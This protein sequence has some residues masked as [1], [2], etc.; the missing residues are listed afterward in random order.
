MRTALILAPL[1]ALS[2][3]GCLARAAV[4]VV[5]APVRIAS[6]AVDLATVSQSEADEQRGRE[7]RRREQRLAELENDY[8]ELQD[9]CLD[10]SDRACREAVTLRAE[11]EAL[12]PTIPV[13]PE[14]D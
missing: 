10:G 3:E 13:E 2:L 7:I 6:R 14:D 5:T 4:D 11:I 9:D 12:L 8:A 1:L